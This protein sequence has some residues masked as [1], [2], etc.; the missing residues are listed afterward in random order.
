MEQAT[1]TTV[2]T[3]LPADTYDRYVL[4]LLDGQERA[5]VDK[6]VEQQCPACI[7]GVQRS[8]NLW[9]VFANTMEQAEP[10]ADFRA[11]LVRIA[12]LSNKVLTVPKRHRSLREPTIL[13]S[14][15]VIIGLVLATLLVFTFLA[16]AQSS[17]SDAQRAANE[18]ARLQRESAEN[19]VN[20][21]QEREINKNLIGKRQAPN[22]TALREQK[23]EQQ[24]LKTQ[25]DLQL[26]QESIKRDSQ[27]T[28]ENSTIVTALANP[29]VKLL[30]FKTTEGAT[31]PAY[32]FVIE[33]SKV[34]F[35]ASKLPAPSD[36]QHQYQLWLVR[37]DEPKFVSAGVF[38]SSEDKPVVV[39]YD[40]DKE[41]ITSLIGILVTEEPLSGSNTPST[42]RVL[43]TPGVSAVA[44]PPAPPPAEK[45]KEN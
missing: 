6:Q 3:G 14:S 43:E 40:Q 24:L 26:A 44:T 32:A 23:L 8:M 16:G 41:V 28:T 10:A 21:Q 33:N 2:C 25:A 12:E 38:M 15:L 36:A 1:E 20:L 35:V 42:V 39:T 18:L 22:E 17:R 30:T 29:G 45:E 4:G 37:K 7:S 9:L 19:L 13:I 27:R 11:R 34:V 31:S 5:H